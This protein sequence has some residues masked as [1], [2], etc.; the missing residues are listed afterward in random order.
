[1]YRCRNGCNHQMTWWW[2]M[3]RCRNECN[4]QMTWW[5]HMYCCRNECNRVLSLC[6]EV[7][8]GFPKLWWNL[9]TRWWNYLMGAISMATTVWKYNWLSNILGNMHYTVKCISVASLK[10]KLFQKIIY[11]FI[12]LTPDIIYLLWLLLLFI[13]RLQF[14]NEN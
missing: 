11:L 2:P 10:K 13:L 8:N 6:I 5:W 3:Y 1:M 7:P 14:N 4:Y 9:A 12:Y